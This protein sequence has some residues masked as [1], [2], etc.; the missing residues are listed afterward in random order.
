MSAL[1]AFIWEH[2]RKLLSQKIRLVTCIQNNLA[3]GCSIETV[4][5][6]SEWRDDL[7]LG[8]LP[9]TLQILQKRCFWFPNFCKHPAYRFCPLQ[10]RRKTVLNEG[11]PSWPVTKHSRSTWAFVG[12]SWT[13]TLNMNCLYGHRLGGKFLLL[14]LWVIIGLSAQQSGGRWTLYQNTVK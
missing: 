12:W 14:L 10:G 5:F 9:K 11:T 13:W 3:A 7:W 6:L 2:L 8:Y 1:F 4:F